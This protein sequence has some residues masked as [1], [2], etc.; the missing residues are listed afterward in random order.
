MP[1]I[2]DFQQGRTNY[3]ALETMRVLDNELGISKR[4]DMSYRD[5]FHDLNVPIGTSAKVKMRFRPK[6]REGLTMDPTP[7]VDKTTTITMLPPFGVD[8][9][10]NDW[11]RI[12][13]M[14]KTEEEIS[15]TIITPAVRRM[16]NSVEKRVAAFIAANTPNVVGAL[17]TNP[18]SVDIFDTI[19][20]QMAELGGWVDGQVDDFVSY[21]AMAGIVAGTRTTFNPQNAIGKAFT[22]GF[23]DHLSGQ[24]VYRSVLLPSFTVG[25]FTGTFA[26]GAAGQSGSSLGITGTNDGDIIKAGT[27]IQIAGI[28][29][30]N[31][32][33]DA[34]PSGASAMTVIVLA[35]ATIASGVATLSIYPE[36][37]GP[38]ETWQTVD[39]LPA[40]T[41][42]IT[43]EPGTTS[44]GGATPKTGTRGFAMAPEAF[45]IV[46]MKWP[47]SVP[48]GTI[49]TISDPDTGMSISIEQNR[50]IREKVTLTRLDVGFGLGVGYAANAAVLIN[51]A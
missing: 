40:A 49:R 34:A 9:S 6:I 12:F 48:S 38:G 28:K 17:G 31:P 36:L 43:I 44:P 1:S 51:A 5:I 30:I 16:A 20:A 41:A 3:V 19:Q 22:K 24:D 10:W 7:I 23:Y 13:D 39:A 11:E 18:S 33:T 29:A 14:V 46:P 47:N 21:R 4:L 37:L 2:N 27:I 8:Y 50:D 25:V 26:V 42:V 35:D 15:K 45:F 32:Q